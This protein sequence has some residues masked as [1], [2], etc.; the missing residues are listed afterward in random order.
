MAEDK[1][2]GERIITKNE[3]RG[4]QLPVCLNEGKQIIRGSVQDGREA[5][6]FQS[7]VQ[8]GHQATA[9]PNITPTPLN[10]RPAE[11]RPIKKDK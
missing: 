10:Q 7:R 4:K 6:S 3:T 11:P 2:K 1:S 8:G 9:I 5:I